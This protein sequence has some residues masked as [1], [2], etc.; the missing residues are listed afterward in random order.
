MAA[1]PGEAETAVE[2]PV[3]IEEKVIKADGEVATRSYQRGK[4]LGKGG[5]ARCYEFTS[6]E[7]GKR[8]AVKVV[9]KITL[10]K[11]RSKQ[12]L[13]SE[14]KIHRTAKQPNIVNFEHFFEDSENVYILLEL[15]P[16]QTL[17]EMVRRRKRLTELEVQCY[18]L[19]IVE[20]LKYLHSNKIIHRDLKLG[21]LFL[22][23]RMEIKLGDF[24]LATVV[25]FD[26]EKKRTICGTPNYIAPEILDSNQG[27]SYEV[28]VWSLGVVLYTLLV[29]KPPFET[30]EVKATYRKIRLN[31]YAFPDHI[32]LSEP[33]KGLI[34]R[35][36]ISDPSKRPTLDEILANDFLNQ[37]NSIP[38]FLPSG[39][40][41]C[42][43]STAY[44]R[45]FE[46][47]V[48]PAR[49]QRKDVAGSLRALRE[50]RFSHTERM[51]IGE[52]PLKKQID[53]TEVSGPE[54]W[55]RKWVDYSS[56]YGLGYELNT[57]AV[58]VFFNDASKLVLSPEGHQFAYIE[59]LDHC[60]EVLT[61]A[62]TDYPKAL[63]KKVIL[64]QHFRSYLDSEC[65]ERTTCEDSSG[66]KPVYVKKWMRTKHAAL[67]RLSCKVVQVVFQ[68]KTQ[69]ILSS[70]AKVASYI[71]KAGIKTNYILNNTLETANIA[72]AKRLKYAKDLLVHMMKTAAK[73]ADLCSEQKS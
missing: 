3:I 31:A 71:D 33:S 63:Q 35:I 30:S 62:L 46:P 15:C 38:K 4:L 68:D 7:T 54:V 73:A 36:L 42:P 17:S 49:T 66:E 28:D 9:P 29:G 22:S 39:F 13:M 72:L 23:E 37:G 47:N 2:T 53:Q 44:L 8:F 25:M 1:Q 26:G 57:G 6:L 59:K 32:P 11:A 43:P 52:K 20:A 56:R 10:K 18:L 69:V 14:I 48:P 61:Y 24:G 27:H 55:I 41:A 45:Q 70:A 50:K 67:F 58:G 12:K 64:L 19:Q 5:F 60:E 34:A 65:G 16:N 21:N 40:T 51:E